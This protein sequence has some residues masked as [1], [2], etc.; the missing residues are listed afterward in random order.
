M[1][2]FSVSFILAE[3]TV[4]VLY[5]ISGTIGRT[6]CQQMRNLPKKLSK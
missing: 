2:N 6:A 1:I 3:R 4:P 5:S